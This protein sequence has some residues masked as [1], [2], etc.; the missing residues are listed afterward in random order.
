MIRNLCLKLTI[1]QALLLTAASTQA[2]SRYNDGEARAWFQNNKLCLG[3]KDSYQV[4]GGFFSR[5]AKVD[6]NQ[7]KLYGVSIIRNDEAVVWESQ[8][9]SET[10]QGVNLATNTCI[11]YGDEIENFLTTIPAK[12]IESGVYSILLRGG[13]SKARRAWFFTR[14]C[15]NNKQGI[16][17]VT[18]VNINEDEAGS[19]RFFCN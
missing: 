12:K 17:T 19:N 16:W 6:E 5:N 18:P 4:G 11:T 13:D 15:V 3:V 1:T 14:A 7:L 10:K 8:S 2:M 9:N